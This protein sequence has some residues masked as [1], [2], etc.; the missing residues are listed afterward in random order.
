MVKRKEQK[1][2]S[3]YWESNLRHEIGGV[4]PTSR[5][6]LFL[7]YIFLINFTSTTFN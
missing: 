3:L 2:V 4:I 7:R 1:K 6:W 5:L